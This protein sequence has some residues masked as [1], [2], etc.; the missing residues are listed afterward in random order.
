MKKS[1]NIPL[2]TGLSASQKV[3]LPSA[4]LDEF[5]SLIPKIILEYFDNMVQSAFN[6][7]FKQHWFNI[8][9]SSLFGFTRSGRE[10]SPSGLNMKPTLTNP[11]ISTSSGIEGIKYMFLMVSRSMDPGVLWLMRSSRMRDLRCLVWPGTPI[12][13]VMKISQMIH[14][15]VSE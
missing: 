10:K 13:M 11:W 15:M 14:Q 8:G 5:E 7:V 12:S 6:V 9:V 1:H 2:N 3:P 4:L